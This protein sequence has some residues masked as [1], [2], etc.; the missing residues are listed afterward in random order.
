M[1]KEGLLKYQAIS[2]EIKHLKEQINRL[3][4]SAYYSPRIIDGMPRAGSNEDRIANLTAKIIDL[5]NL[6]V[7]KLTKLV[8]CHIEIEQAIEA[9]DSA[10]RLLLRMKYIDGMK[11]WEIANEIDYSVQRVYQ[12][13]ADALKKL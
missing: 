1:D 10:D 2:K 7:T 8:D 9:L 5:D 12:M 3:R 11:W 6:L 4:D 13:H